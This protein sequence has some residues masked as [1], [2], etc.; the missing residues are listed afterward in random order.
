MHPIQDEW[1][2]EFYEDLAHVVGSA[3]LPHDKADALFTAIAEHP[4]LQGYL[5]LKRMPEAYHSR[6]YGYD[7]SLPDRSLAD[8]KKWWASRYE[9]E[10]VRIQTVDKI[11]VA[12]WVV[13]V[14]EARHDA[15]T[16]FGGGET[17]DRVGCVDILF[18]LARR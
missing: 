8:I 4:Q 16:E 9:G 7:I 14:V 13:H 1:N 5:R 2:N 12:G 15:E 6:F 10:D 11:R 18:A 17:L 3:T